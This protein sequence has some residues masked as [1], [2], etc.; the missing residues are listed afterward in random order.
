MQGTGVY[1]QEN[2]GWESGMI[3]AWRANHHGRLIGFPHTTVRF[4]DLR[5]FDPRSYKESCLA[6]PRPDFVAVGGDAIN[7]TYLDGG[8]P[9]DCL[10]KVEALRYLQF[11]GSSNNV[12]GTKSVHSKRRKI[13]VIGDYLY[14]NTFLQMDLLNKLGEELIEYDLTI[15]PHPACP[16]SFS[17]FQNLKFKVSDKP[18]HELVHKFDIAYTSCFTT[19][20]LDAY[21]AGLKIIS[22]LDPTTLNLSPLRGIK[23]V[24][25]VSSEDDLRKAL[26]TASINI[27]GNY[28]RVNYFHTEPSL[29]R[30]RKLLSSD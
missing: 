2:Q 17:S 19:A 22:V 16:I 5:Y 13:L 18:I 23:G 7:N 21:G 6:L 25:F 24:Q 26:L 4:W 14:S 15:K 28:K 11:E 12:G 8:Y 29:P 10:I 30:W 27:K 1:L 20:A 3:H 9:S